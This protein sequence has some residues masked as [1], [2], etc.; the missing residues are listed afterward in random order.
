MTR[1]PVSEGSYCWLFHSPTVWRVVGIMGP[2]GPGDHRAFVEHPDGWV[3]TAAINDL[4]V[5]TP[6]ELASYHL[7]GAVA[8]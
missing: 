1:D 5:L 8:L 6:E 3:G 4:A 2:C 7:E